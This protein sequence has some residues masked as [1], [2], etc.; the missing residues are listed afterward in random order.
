MV[1]FDTNILLLT[2]QPSAVGRQSSGALSPCVFGRHHC[3]HTGMLDL[4]AKNSTVSQVALSKT[5]MTWA[6]VQKD[7]GGKQMGLENTCQNFC[8]IN[9]WLWN[10][11]DFPLLLGVLIL[12]ALEGPSF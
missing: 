3:Q 1:S 2:S 9:S 5:H 11:R 8:H 10:G 12:W 7:P 6:Q 4:Q